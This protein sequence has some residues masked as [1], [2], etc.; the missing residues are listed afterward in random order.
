M[1]N[2]SEILERKKNNSK[3][4]NEEYIQKRFEGACKPYYPLFIADMDYKLPKNIIENINKF[5]SKGDFGYYDIK[6]EFKYSIINWYNKT[7]NLNI[8]KNDIIPTT[9]ALTTTY[10]IINEVVK[11]DGKAMIFTPVYGP[12]KDIVLNNGLKLIKEKLEIKNGKYYINF[13]RVKETVEKENI[14]C[15]LFCN[16]HNPSG[17]IWN[18][19]EIKKLL[20]IAREKDILVISD[21]VHGDLVLYDNK[22]SSMYALKN[23]YDKFIVIGS[24]NKTFNIAS[25]NVGYSLIPNEEIREKVVNGLNKRKL[26]VN[27][28]GEEASNICYN[29]GFTWVKELIKEIEKNIE[30]VTSLLK[31]VDCNIMIPD[32]GYLVWVKFNK[33]KDSLEFSKKLA[34]ETGVLLESG[35]RFVDNYKGYLRINVATSSKIIREGMEKI[36]NYYE[37]I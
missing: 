27:R 32:A 15:I 7:Q 9:G 23:I 30:I 31:N 26:H 36:I 10:A 37:K 11:K 33:V 3:K 21:E 34:K 22:F 6:D 17:R 14:S 12:F 4:W 16:P 20:E 1:Y 25:L 28:V 24:P 18:E 19:N 13:E 29:I 2:F 8:N 5:I 35:S